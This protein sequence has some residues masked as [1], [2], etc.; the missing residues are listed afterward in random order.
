MASDEELIA[1]AQE[2]IKAVYDDGIA[3]INGRDYTFCKMTFSERRKVFAYMT[4]IQKELQEGN[5]T[6]VDSK[7]FKEDIEKTIFR[8]VTLEGM[9]LLKKNPFENYI[10]DYVP[11][12]TTALGVISYPF[13]KGGDGK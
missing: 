1:K 5:F 4:S 6:F 13:L 3:T 12:I 7:I 10:E 11:F 9:S 2:Q 8:N